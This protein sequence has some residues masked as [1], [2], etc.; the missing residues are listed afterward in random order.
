M[1]AGMREWKVELVWRRRKRE[2]GGR[3]EMMRSWSSRGSFVKG[4]WARG[5]WRGAEVERMGYGGGGGGVCGR[6]MMSSSKI[7]N[8]ILRVCGIWWLVMVV[9]VV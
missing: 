3:W 8:A 6:G 9:L 5:G 1:G 2:L 4:K 7:R